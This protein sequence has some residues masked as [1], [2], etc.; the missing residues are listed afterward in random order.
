MKL[1]CLIKKKNYQNMLQN[2][3]IFI[4]IILI[5]III[6]IIAK[7]ILLLLYTIFLLKFHYSISCSFYLL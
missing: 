7:I 6:P 3:N 4:I 5:L 1:I 2:I